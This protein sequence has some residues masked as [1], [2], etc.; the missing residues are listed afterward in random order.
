MEED[1]RGMRFSYKDSENISIRLSGKYQL[2]N[3]VTAWEAVHVPG[4]LKKEKKRAVE[5]GFFDTEWFGRFTCISERPVFL[6]DGAHNEDAAKRLRESIEAYFPG[7]KLIYIMGVFQDKEYE[8]I[9]RLTI[10]YAKCVYT[11]DLPNKERTLSAQK[12]KEAVEAQSEY[13]PAYAVGEIKQAVKEAL[14]N[15]DEDDVILAF[16]SLSY[17][18]K[19]KEA[20]EKEQDKRQM[21]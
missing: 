15:A 10:P 5:T 16:G 2:I 11:V 19:V 13:V 14:E 3:A 9:I 20:V 18:G 21:Y 1:Y 17:L 4:L 7:R 12:L 8:K 6:V